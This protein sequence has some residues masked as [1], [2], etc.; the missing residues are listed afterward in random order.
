M[1]TPLAFK[2]ALPFLLASLAA[3][4]SSNDSEAEDTGEDGTSGPASAS[5]TSPTGPGSSSSSTSSATTG[6]DVS[7]STTGSSDS[8]GS[9]TD[10]STG[11]TTGDMTT[12]GGSTGGDDNGIDLPATITM[13]F[14]FSGERTA[15]LCNFVF[16]GSNQYYLASDISCGTGFSYMSFRHLSNSGEYFVQTG[17]LAEE[18]GTTPVAFLDWSHGTPQDVT[19]GGLRLRDLPEATDMTLETTFHETVVFRFDGE[20]VTLTVFDPK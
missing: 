7:S 2:L 11:S 10:E 8:D 1:N 14:A 20:D 13:T 4:C 9:T 15:A 5:D 19:G 12:G 16:E 3:G 6:D 18:D 17:A